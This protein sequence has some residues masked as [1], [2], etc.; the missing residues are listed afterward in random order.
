MTFS[1]FI[2][3]PF[4]KEQ[5]KLNCYAMQQNEI[6]TLQMMHTATIRHFIDLRFR[7]KREIYQKKLDDEAIE[8]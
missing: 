7:F 3:T 5:L 1:K 4:L 6:Y 8:K 2:K